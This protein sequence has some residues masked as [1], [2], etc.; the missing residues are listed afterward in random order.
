MSNF[1]KQRPRNKDFVIKRKI[2]AQ[3]KVFDSELGDLLFPKEDTVMVPIISRDGIWEKEEV[4]WLKEHV[5]K[6]SVC[7][8]IGSNVGY[9]ALQMAKLTGPEGFVYAVEPNRD[10]L[11]FL[12]LNVK[13]SGYKNVKVIKK[14]ASNKGGVRKLYL[15]RV[16]FGDSRLFDPRSTLGGGN[17]LEMGFK[18][19]PSYRLVRAIKIDDALKDKKIDIVLIDTQGFDHLVIQGMR[20]IISQFKPKILTEFVPQWISDMGWDPLEVLEEYKDHGYQIMSLDFDV[21]SPVSPKKLL[22][23]IKQSKK[24]YTNL[25]LLPKINL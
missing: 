17:H 3:V 14:A 22:S 19:K 1:S 8:N 20:E 10:V 23:D 6:G 11:P 21:K 4:D 5:T 15:N 16:N 25:S 13:N 2:G 9:F 7:L 24:L 12:K 18:N